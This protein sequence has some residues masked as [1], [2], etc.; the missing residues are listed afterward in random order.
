M[1]SNIPRD[2]LGV[3]LQQSG[4]VSATVIEV[5]EDMRLSN[6][7]EK[8]GEL[9]VSWGRVAP[10]T[11]K[12]FAEQ[13]PILLLQKQKFPIG[14]YLEQAGLLTRG[15]IHEVLAKQ[16]KTG[17]LFGDIVVQQ[18]KVSRATIDFFLNSLDPER[19][20]SLENGRL[21]ADFLSRAQEGLPAERDAP[22]TPPAPVVLPPET[23]PVRPVRP[24][25]PLPRSSSR[26]RLL[27]FGGFGV[28]VVLLALATTLGILVFGNRNAVIGLFNRG[29]QHLGDREYA[30][31]I[32]TY[33]RLLAKDANY[34]QAWTNRGYAL[35]G[36]KRYDE[37]LDSC[38]T[39]TLI[40]PTAAYAWNCQGEALHN[41]QRDEEAIVIYDR[42]LEIDGDDPV[43]WVNRS[44]SLLE[45]LQLAPAL[46]SVDRAIERLETLYQSDSDPNLE[47][48]LAIALS[49]KGR[50]LQQQQK[51]QAA[52][53]TFEQALLHSK[54]YFPALRGLGIALKDLGEH[55]RANAQ[56]AKIVDRVALSTSQQA[57]IWFYKGLNLCAAGQLSRAQRA[58]TQ[59]LELGWNDVAVRDAQANC[60]SSE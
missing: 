6:T 16:Q 17:M 51:H 42:A 56:F 50:I 58:F 8:L 3:I 45:A 25:T 60:S 52:F 44:I 54:Q 15:Q 7:S 28:V 18:G 41:L 5:A 57:E 1:S 38:Q 47:R 26:G 46:K 37:M 22:P 23:P 49:H 30:E 39:A 9:L 27:V 35:A 11:V 34:Y 32:E 48:E 53:D 14:H 13:W 55:E 43:L 20:L 36:L 12:F 4:L 10:Q 19:E 33:D 21:L 40:E 31:A 29:N 2:P 59:A 24:V